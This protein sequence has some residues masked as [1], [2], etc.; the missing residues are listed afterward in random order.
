M[1]AGAGLPDNPRNERETDLRRRLAFYEGF[2]AIINDNV[3]RSGELLREAEQRH[4]AEKAAA[5]SSREDQRELLR[6]LAK[7]A[8]ALSGLAVA[9]A[10]RIDAALSALDGTR[11][12]ATPSIGDRIVLE[13]GEHAIVEDPL[14]EAAAAGPLGTGEVIAPLGE[15]SAGKADSTPTASFEPAAAAPPAEPLE[16]IAPPPEY[17]VHEALQEGE[18]VMAAADVVPD[19]GRV[20]SPGPARIP[21]TIRFAPSSVQPRLEGGKP[22]LEVV[23]HGIPDLASAQALRDAVRDSGAVE[24]LAVR[25]FSGGM[26]RLALAPREILSPDRLRSLAAPFV[27]EEID[28]GPGVIAVR[29]VTE[30]V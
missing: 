26:M 6:G 11:E 29:I 3:R 28:R 30:P 5:E 8:A 18:A 10:A 22:A 27:L 17:P 15:P 9:L 25:E 16:M 2:D 21:D 23:V 1:E 4:A 7:E 19:S 13:S 14:A 24:S 12:A 20:E